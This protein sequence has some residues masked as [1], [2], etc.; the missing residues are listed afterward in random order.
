MVWMQ[1]NLM[2]CSE[3]V[4]HGVISM[5]MNF[6]KWCKQGCHLCDW[7]I[8]ALL[9][10]FIWFFFLI[11][12]FFILKIVAFTT[13][14]FGW[15]KWIRSK[16]S[17]IEDGWSWTQIKTNKKKTYPKNHKKKPLKKWKRTQPKITFYLNSDQIYLRAEKEAVPKFENQ[18]FKHKI[19]EK[20]DHLSKKQ[21]IFVSHKCRRL[22]LIFLSL[23]FPR[24]IFFLPQLWDNS[25]KERHHALGPAIL[26][27]RC[28]VRPKKAQPGL[29]RLNKATLGDSNQS[30]NS[31]LHPHWLQTIRFLTFDSFENTLHNSLWCLQQGLQ[32]CT[33]AQLPAKKKQY[34]KENK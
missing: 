3:M 11:T 27:S 21:A 33:W 8:L 2:H 25:K 6:M 9:Y 14:P 4:M 16:K 32:W 13:N 15:K 20:D 1:C 5:L 30:R 31:A 24:N 23:L 28:L 7:S 18:N 34:E 29:I 17:L 12:W 22:F 10:I 26:S 19:R